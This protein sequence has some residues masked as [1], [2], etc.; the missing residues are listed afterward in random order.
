MTAL[1]DQVLAG[2]SEAVV[3]LY[4]LYSPKI[5]VYLKKK[6]PEEDA[7]DVLSEVFLEAID[8]LPTLKDKNLFLAWLYKIAHNK[9]VDLYRK[10]KIKSVLLSQIPFFEIVAQEISQPEFVYEKN[11]IRD[12]IEN[13]FKKLSDPHRKILSLHYEH[14][15]SVKH[16]AETLHLSF[17]ATESLLFRARKSFKNAYE[18][19]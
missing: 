5:L 12:T 6:L 13:V 3:K 1:I 2:N 4:R 18:R 19:A 10:Q 15:M 8:G 9:I 11:K 7:K 14:G 16:I 17:K